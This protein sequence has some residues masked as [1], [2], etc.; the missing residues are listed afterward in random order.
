MFNNYLRPAIVSFLAIAL[1]TGIAYPLV[2]TGAAQALFPD[3]ANGSLIKDVSGQVIGSSLIG[4]PFGDAKH[5]WSRPSNPGPGA[6]A[7]VAAA[8]AVPATATTPEVPA[9]AA[10]TEAPAARYDPQATAGT[11]KTPVGDDFLANTKANVDALL[12]ADPDN[13]LPIP[14]D[15]VTASASGLDPHISPEAAAYQIHRVAQKN[16]LSEDAVRK[17]VEAHTEQPQLG[18]L[19]MPRVN[20]LELNLALDAAK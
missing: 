5:F 12:K 8:P 4:Q 14:Q 7:A 19:G 15:L 18:V 20:V 13:K 1:L 11:N 2:T 3:K 9:V 6:V 10:V 17:L 16:G